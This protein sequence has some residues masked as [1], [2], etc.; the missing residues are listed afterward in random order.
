MFDAISENGVATHI[1]SLGPYYTQMLLIFL[2][3]LHFD[4]IPQNE[5]GLVGP[6][7]PQY[8]IV[9]DNVNFYSGLLIRDW[10]TTHPRMVMVFLPP[11]SPFLNPI[12]FFSSRRWKYMSIGLKIKGPCSMMNAVC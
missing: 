10:F 7:L 9:W 8:V 2:D 12:E 5:K 4:L 11:Y 6:H 3:R 1:P